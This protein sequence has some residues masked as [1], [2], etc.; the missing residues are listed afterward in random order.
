MLWTIY[1]LEVVLGAEDPPQTQELSRNGRTFI[2]S[3]LS[4]GQRR[5]ERLISS[6]P[7]DYLRPHWQPG[8]RI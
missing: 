7:A 3:H 6:E 2:V 5:I 1:P 4:D 8:N